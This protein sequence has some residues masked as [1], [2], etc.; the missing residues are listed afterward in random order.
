MIVQTLVALA[1]FAH[2]GPV[3]LP[4][5]S[6]PP[7]AGPDVSDGKPLAP[8][9]AGRLNA[10]AEL[11]RNDREAAIQSGYLAAPINFH[12][13]THSGDGFMVPP[14]MRDEIWALTFEGDDILSLA[15]P[16]PTASNRVEL[17]ADESTPWGATGV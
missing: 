4:A 6:S 9:I 5:A 13:E 15:N 2:A 3:N 17:T 14:A 12:Q 10:M 7:V 1:L 16:E 11:A 8:A